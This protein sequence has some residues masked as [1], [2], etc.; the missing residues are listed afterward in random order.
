[1]DQIDKYYM[2]IAIDEALK[3][4]SNVYPNP[5]V[6]A[7][8]VKDNKIISAAHH[9]DF[10]GQHAEAIAINNINPDIS[11]ATLYVTLEP[12]N[13]KGK[14]GPCSD[15]IDPKIFNRVVIGTKDP[16]QLASGSSKKLMDRG[17]KV[18]QNIFENE[19][20]NINRRFFTFHEKKRPYVILKMASTLDGFIAEKN[21]SSKWITNEKSR[22]SVH[23][24]RSTCDTILVGR[25]TIQK[26]N[27]SLTSHGKGKDPRV[28][29]FDR[30]NKINKDLKVYQNNPIVFT[31]ENLSKKPRENISNLLTYLYENSYQ[32]LLVEGGG[33]TFTHFLENK[34][35]DELQIYYAPRTIGEGIPLYHGKKSLAM[36][37]EI[38]LEKIEQFGNDIKITYKKK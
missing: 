25:H 35:F 16:N 18:I 29:F 6:G 38:V 30:E 2:K 31:M 20:R 3:G 22:N 15:I 23:E 33:I 11:D 21:G 37:L 8:I 9:K 10:G 17:I 36:K 32:S 4:G 26:D 24:L 28:V 7:V 13:H 27:P 34:I 19:C 12:C 14:T 1:M 5:R